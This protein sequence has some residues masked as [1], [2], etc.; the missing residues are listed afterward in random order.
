MSREDFRH[1]VELAQHGTLPGASDSLISIVEAL[2][3][4]VARQNKLLADL[5]ERTGNP[6]L[7]N[8]VRKH[9]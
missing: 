2:L 1:F 6:V 5:A 9:G 3:G 8:E 4:E 7:A